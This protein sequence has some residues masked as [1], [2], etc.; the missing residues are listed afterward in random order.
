MLGGM[1]DAL[2]RVRIRV[3]SSRRQCFT[4]HFG[5]RRLLADVI[6]SSLQVVLHLVL[7]ADKYA[8]A[9]ASS[10]AAF[11]RI[12]V[13]GQVERLLRCLTC[14]TALAT[15]DAPATSS[16]APAQQLALP[17]RKR[18]ARTK[19]GRLALSQ[20]APPAQR[21]ATAAAGDADAATAQQC[22]QH[23]ALAVALHLHAHMV[24]TRA[25]QQPLSSKD[26]SSYLTPIGLED[27]LAPFLH[28]T[29]ATLVL[30][31]CFHWL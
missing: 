17:Q 27:V 11:A 24:A 22:E 8:K 21:G 10:E 26:L 20:D 15:S 1:R 13:D 12:G 30:A 3:C 31:Q 28:G 16:L 7:Q 19:A 5:R 9:T 6:S 4:H 18:P 2:S 14:N 29:E 25:R 23:P